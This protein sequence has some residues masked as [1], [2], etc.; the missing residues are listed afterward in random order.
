MYLSNA[1]R[2]RLVLAYLCR[3][4]GRISDYLRHCC[5]SKNPLDKELPWWS[6]EAIDWAAKNLNADHRVFEWGSGGS[7]VF[8]SRL[9]KSVLSIEN[10][11]E[12]HRRMI[13]KIQQRSILNLQVRKK[14][15][16]LTNQEGFE[17]SEYCEALSESYDLIVI[18]GED[19]F[20]PCSSWSARE[21]CFKRAEKWVNP[22]GFILV[23]DSWRYPIIPRESRA[24]KTV[25]FQSIGPCRKGV[26]TTDLH[27]Y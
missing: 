15:I 11:A 23:D 22:N 20:G 7:S 8:L 3:H 1:Q 9:C 13:R 24:K 27:F 4:P 10:D 25:R 26:T 2:T 21:V 5:F 16:C 18:D 17:N 19:S 6:Y 12:W 14:E